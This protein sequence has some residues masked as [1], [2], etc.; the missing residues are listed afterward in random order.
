MSVLFQNARARLVPGTRSVELSFRF[1][2]LSEE[3][4]E[5]EGDSIGWHLFDAE[6]GTL[7]VDGPRHKPGAKMAFTIELPEED[8][9]YHVFI[10]PMRENERWYY[11][12]DWPSCCWK[13]P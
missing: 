3:W 4:G 12:R 1:V 6:T 13:L 8:G 9:R 10:S 2:N 7:I 11:E 5:A